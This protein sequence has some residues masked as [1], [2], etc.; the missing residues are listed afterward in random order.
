MTC[1]ALF[2]GRRSATAPLRR[3]ASMAAVV[4][5]AIAA[6][7]TGQLWIGLA[8]IM[9]F[10][11]PHA[12]YNA[13]VQVW[14]ADRFGAGHGQGA[15]M[16]LLSTTFC[17]ANILMAAAGALLTLIDTRLVL[18]AGALLTAWAATRMGAW[19]REPPVAAR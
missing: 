4:A 14:A 12:F 16:G 19:S 8:G 5:L 2:A 6:L 1:A 11:L 15:V 7:G 18:V 9:L 17:L 13:T 3:A 10:G